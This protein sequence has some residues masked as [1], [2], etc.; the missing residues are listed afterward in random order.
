MHLPLESQAY[1]ESI[2]LNHFPKL[3]S[4]GPSRH[5]T[6]ISQVGRVLLSRYLSIVPVESGPLLKDARLFNNCNLSFSL[7]LGYNI[8]LLG[9]LFLPN[10]TFSI[11]S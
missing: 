4:W 9:A 10:Y 6:Q 1:I 8:K 7:R 11:S 2:S 5:L 3:T